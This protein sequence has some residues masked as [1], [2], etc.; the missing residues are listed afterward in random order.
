[1]RMKFSRTFEELK[2]EL[3]EINGSWT[4][5]GNTKVFRTQS[6][7]ILNWYETTGT[8]L[9]QGK[10]K[11]KEELEEQVSLALDVTVKGNKIPLDSDVEE[12]VM[13]PTDSIEHKYLKNDFFE[14]EIV[15]AIV[16][17]VGTES[18][19]VIETLENRIKNF[20]YETK[21][22]RISELLPQTLEP[23]EYD[24]IKHFIS[25]GDKLRGQTNNY[26]LATGAVSE[27]LNYRKDNDTKKIVYI[28]NS[29]KHPDEIEFLKKI[30]GN[31]FFL[32]GIHSDAKRRH[33]Y[34]QEDKG[35]SA[36]QASELIEIDEDEKIPHGQRTRDAYHL[37]DFFLSLG[38]NSDYVKN[39]IQRF[40]D[41]IFSNPYQNPTFDEFA[42]FMAFSSSIRSSDLSRQ[43]GAVL[44]K[45]K[46]IIATGANDCPQ[47]GGG[48]Y[49]AEIDSD[50]GEVKEVDYGKDFMRSEDSNKIAQSDIISQIITPL[51]KKNLVTEENKEDVYQII[52]QSPISDL[53]EFGRVVHAEMEA[54]LSCARAG[55]TTTGATL[56]CTTFPCHNCAKHIID[57]GIERVVYVEP[58]P[59]SRAFELHSESIDL[60]T[61]L[62]EKTDSERVSFEPFT[63]VG[64]RRFLDLF[65]MSLGAGIKIKRKDK[66][67]KKLEWEEKTAKM[68]TPLLPKSYL[69][70]EQS[71]IEIWN[72]R[73]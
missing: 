38:K 73:S 42:M 71:A 69:D 63:G 49:W 9:F 1:M 59:K 72:S 41:L 37:S 24:R 8:I 28:V 40:L 3:K 16:N 64:A 35:C 34:L 17:A 53:T 20:G 51:L 7:G 43:V 13:N 27:I 57:A 11:P 65:S 48:Q 70:I 19:S 44:T 2:D 23:H 36:S 31:G 56:Y 6:G 21:I 68:R 62:E 50:T 54:L 39:T 18:K 45:N 47:S 15:I 52:K 58:Y 5:K 14:S 25:E 4:D 61:N 26:I 32:F 66:Q 33:K 55:I 30:Y 12:I 67:G 46:Q 22:I 10:E 60:K 29:L